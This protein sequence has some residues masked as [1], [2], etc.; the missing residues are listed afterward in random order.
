MSDENCSSRPARLADRW[1]FAEWDTERR[2]PVGVDIPTWM[3]AA[4][5]SARVR[6]AA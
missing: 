5:E 1:Q 2:E 3:C 6:Q 4:V